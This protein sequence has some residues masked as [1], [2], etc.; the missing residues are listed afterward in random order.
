MH[1]ALF[2]LL[3]RLPLLQRFDKELLLLHPDQTSL[4]RQSVEVQTSRVQIEEE[5]QQGG[6]LWG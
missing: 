3:I 1:S 4:Q 6:S 2:S 5:E